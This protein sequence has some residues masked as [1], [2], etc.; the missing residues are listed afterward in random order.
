MVTLTDL[1][2][3]VESLENKPA[4]LRDGADASLCV[5]CLQECLRTAQQSVGH[6]HNQFFTQLGLTD[7]QVCYRVA[8]KNKKKKNL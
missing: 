2:N 3:K 6:S 8:P 1:L 4:F 5:S 7:Q